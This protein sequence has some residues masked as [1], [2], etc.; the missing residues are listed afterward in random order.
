MFRYTILLLIFLTL[1]LRANLGDDVKQLVAR[2]GTPTNFSE[3]SPTNPFGTIVF[4][5]GSYTLIVFLLGDKEVGARVSKTDQSAFT[6]AERETI[7]STDVAGSQWVSVPS[8]DP[9]FLQWTRS[10]Q[11]KAT[12][13][14]Q[15]NML[16]FTSDA[17]TQ[18]LKAA[19]KPAAPTSTAPAA[20]TPPPVAK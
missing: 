16:I 15:K 18:A 3:A 13:D 9:A 11:A 5:A 10:D 2:Y 12:Y 19:A 14:K 20:A 1:P 4:Q 17:M 6:D 8:P 7:M